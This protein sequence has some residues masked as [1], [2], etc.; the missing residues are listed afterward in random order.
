MQ[1]GPKEQ[2][3]VL[4]VDD[5]E[6]I[7]LAVDRIVRRLDCGV[8]H[9]R[10]GEQALE[11]LQKQE[12]AVV[13]LD[14]KMPGMDG[15]EVHR[16][17][18][19]AGYNVQVIIITGYATIETA[20]EAMKQ[21]AFDFIPK[22]FDKEHLRLV[23][24]RALNTI[25]LER[26][27]FRLEKERRRAL[28]DLDTEKSRI[29]TILESLPNGVIVTNTEGSVVLM[30]QTARQIL[31]KKEDDI[32]CEIGE[33]LED[34]ELCELIRSQS[35]EAQ[36]DDISYELQLGGGHFY[37]VRTNPVLGENGECLG[38]VVVFGDISDLKEMDRLKSEFVAKVSHELRSPLS[39]IHEQM[40]LV[41]QDMLEQEQ[42][43]KEQRILSRAKEKTKG[44]LSLIEDLLDLSRVE[45]GS[46]YTE[47]QRVDLRE[48][49]NSQVDFFRDRAVEKDQEL[50]FEASGEEQP[51]VEADPRALESVLSNLIGNAVKYT[52]EQGRIAV[53]LGPVQDG[54]V[55][56]EVEDNGIGI[57]EKEQSRIFE[58]FYRSKN[59]Q[60][61]NISGT[62]LGLPI[63][64]GILDDM[65][66]S[67]S[68]R[69]QYG[70]GSTFVVQLPVASG[71]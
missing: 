51:I 30:N 67:I 44:M 26:D 16:R 63:V 58:R 20:I 33:C 65:G 3:N 40:A 41:L 35:R 45:A 5:E 69:S 48:M 57:E 54:Q 23:V 27:R 53:R 64:K 31:D 68:L 50:S 4:V 29:R 2:L 8:L 11:T 22:P 13:L 15:M 28:L 62:G 36:Q 47:V 42:P 7:R 18:R 21:G 17:I 38:S 71:S 61:R 60:T 25:R 32:G 55:R 49:L 39:T 66:G 10:N 12:V 43:E 6:N 56:V 14:L 9:A 46:A 59:K 24:D 34:G 1:S 70:Q 37:M 19:E 52:P